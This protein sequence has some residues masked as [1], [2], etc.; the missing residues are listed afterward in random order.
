MCLSGDGSGGVP[1]RAAA[2]LGSNSGRK[3]GS[4]S[5]VWKQQVGGVGMVAVSKLATVPR[6]SCFTPL[7]VI[8][9]LL[10][11]Y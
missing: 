11:I 1:I 10:I 7:N 5:L 3:T 9:V 6:T 4:R 2:I 8:N